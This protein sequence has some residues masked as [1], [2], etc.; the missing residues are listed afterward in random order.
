MRSLV[1]DVAHHLGSVAHMVEL[2]RERHG[3]LH[4]G[5][6]PQFVVSLGEAEAGCTAEKI[7]RSIQHWDPVLKQAGGRTSGIGGVTVL[8]K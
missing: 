2:V 5:G 4:L 1:R 3:P 6:D 7:V 8:G